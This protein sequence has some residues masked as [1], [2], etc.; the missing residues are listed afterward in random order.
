MF[1]TAI[2]REGL[3]EDV[4]QIYYD[5]STNEFTDEFR[6]EGGHGIFN[7]YRILSPNVIYLFKLKKK[8]ML[9]FGLNGEYIE[10]I[11]ESYDKVYGDND[12]AVDRIFNKIRRN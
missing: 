6:D 11:Y 10:L 12:Y 1:R 9:V 7:I 3:L 4:I 2:G 8:D 5:A